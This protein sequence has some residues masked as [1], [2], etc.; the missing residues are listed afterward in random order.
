MIGLK[1]KIIPMETKTARTKQSLK[2]A[3]LKRL[4]I[5]RLEDKKML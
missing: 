1:K 3:Q 4:K 2:L 5:L